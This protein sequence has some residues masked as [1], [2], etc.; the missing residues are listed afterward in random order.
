MHDRKSFGSDK[1][2]NALKWL[3]DNHEDYRNHVTIN[4]SIIN[5][6]ESKFIAVELLESIGRISDPL[7]ED[8]CQD[9]FSMDDPDNDD[10][11]DDRLPLTSSGIVD[12][13]NIQ[14][15]LCILRL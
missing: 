13:N 3:F 5:D 7:A 10:N 1:V 9:G 12:T 6:W 15:I 11:T 2:Y 14:C 8:A 4:E